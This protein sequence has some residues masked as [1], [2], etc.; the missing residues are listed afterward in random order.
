SGVTSL[1]SW[2]NIKKSGICIFLF[3]SRTPCEERSSLIKSVPGCEH[4]KNHNQFLPALVTNS[5]QIPHPCA[6]SE[7]GN[8]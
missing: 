5:V 4:S 6:S 2:K 7:A 8:K 3:S 1:C